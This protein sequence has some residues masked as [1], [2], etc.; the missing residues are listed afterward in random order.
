MLK[1]YAETIRYVLGCGRETSRSRVELRN[2]ES[3]LVS[4]KW[5]GFIHRC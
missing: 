5:I 4:L 2:I 3:F 1:V